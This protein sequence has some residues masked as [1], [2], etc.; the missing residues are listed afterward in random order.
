MMFW[1][2]HLA[3]IRF[4]AVQARTRSSDAKARIRLTAEMDKISSRAVMA[5]IL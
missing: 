2:V 1:K 5:K 3:Q 4:L